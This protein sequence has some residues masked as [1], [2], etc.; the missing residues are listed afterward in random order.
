MDP[1]N[2]D[3]LVKLFELPRIKRA[4]DDLREAIPIRGDLDLGDECLTIYQD[5]D[6]ELVVTGVRIERDDSRTEIDVTLSKS[7]L[8]AAEL[9]WCLGLVNAEMLTHELGESYATSAFLARQGDF[10]SMRLGVRLNTDEI[11]T[12]YIHPGPLPKP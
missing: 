10:T 9:L 6:G 1:S 3:L 11:D 12:L 2:I 7:Q 4:L 5:E 8:D